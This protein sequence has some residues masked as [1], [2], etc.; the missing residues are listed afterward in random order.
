MNH[1]HEHEYIVMDSACFLM[2]RYA[3][4]LGKS[5]AE[6]STIDMYNFAKWVRKHNERINKHKQ[7]QKKKINNE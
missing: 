6:L 7:I 1:K 2:V 4:E 5:T 3:D